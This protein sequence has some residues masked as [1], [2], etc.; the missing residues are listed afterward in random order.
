MDVMKAAIQRAGNLQLR[1][2]AR[3]K[4][5]PLTVV[6]LTGVLNAVRILQL[7]HQRNGTAVYFVI[8]RVGWRYVLE[9]R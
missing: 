1:E 7:G 6:R 3:S 2:A 4:S 9:E 5:A 8:M